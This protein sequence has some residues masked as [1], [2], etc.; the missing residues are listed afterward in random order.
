VLLLP[1]LRISPAIVPAIAL[2]IAEKVLRASVTTL[3]TYGALVSTGEDRAHW[4]HEVTK[5]EERR[6]VR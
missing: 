3:K 6:Q 5:A 1:A 2:D 4:E